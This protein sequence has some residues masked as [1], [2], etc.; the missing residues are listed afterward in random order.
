MGYAKV[1]GIAGSDTSPAT[2]VDAGSDADDMRPARGVFC[3][4]AGSLVFWVVVIRAVLL[5]I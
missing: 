3:A 1:Y 4:A 5:G 2:A